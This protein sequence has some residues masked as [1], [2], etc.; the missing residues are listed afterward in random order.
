M[1]DLNKKEVS[2]PKLVLFFLAIVHLEKLQNQISK[3]FF[4][5]QSL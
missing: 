3:T 5:E 1:L 4:D 2:T